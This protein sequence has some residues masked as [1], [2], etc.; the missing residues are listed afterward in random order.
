MNTRQNGKRCATEIVLRV[1]SSEDVDLLLSRDWQVP[2]YCSNDEGDR[3]RSNLELNLRQGTANDSYTKA[4][5]V[6][7]SATRPS[8]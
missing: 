4:E 8:L 5:S 2:L 6:T 3:V 7:T 1:C